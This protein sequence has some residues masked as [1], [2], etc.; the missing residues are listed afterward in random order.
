MKK[1]VQ[2]LGQCD[3]MKVVIKDLH[4]KSSGVGGRLW[5]PVGQSVNP[6]LPDPDVEDKTG[7]KIIT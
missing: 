5:V 2:C 6:M 4:S 3:I 1:K 7:A